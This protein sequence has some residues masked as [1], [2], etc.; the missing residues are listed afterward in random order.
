MALRVEPDVSLGDWWARREEP[1]EL[2]CTVGPSGYDAY[3][4]VLMPLAE[5]DA[6][7]LPET[8]G[9]LDDRVLAAL[10][11][12]LA[13]HT[14]TPDDCFSCLWDGWGPVPPGPRVRLP[15]RE[16]LLFRGPLADAQDWGLD[17]T[18]VPPPAAVW[19]ADRAWFLAFDVDPDWAVV[20]GSAPAVA[21]VVE[22]AGLD[23][24]PVGWGALT[25]PRP[26]RG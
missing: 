2:L 26:E 1:W 5:D 22:G 14:T 7:G 12:V 3:A 11:A 4:Q 8:G 10:V 6:M 18:W 23:T 13:G 21:A 17:L 15:N 9:N 19:P 20:G 16:Y 25:D 24:R